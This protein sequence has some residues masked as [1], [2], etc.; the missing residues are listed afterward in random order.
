[1]SKEL[2]ATEKVEI[3]KTITP[4]DLRKKV[5]LTKTHTRRHTNTN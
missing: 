3:K 1:M 2:K 5:G 4:E